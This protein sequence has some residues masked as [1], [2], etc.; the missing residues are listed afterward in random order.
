MH[1]IGKATVEVTDGS[2]QDPI[3]T[4]YTFS[5]AEPG[6][7]ILDKDGYMEYI[8]S[9][10]GKWEAFGSEWT[11]TTST[12]G[13]AIDFVTGISYNGATVL[14]SKSTVRSASTS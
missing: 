4:G 13:T 8:W 9:S 1:F 12:S 3:I 6:D 11:A 10:A 14:V 2:T 7:V 5:N